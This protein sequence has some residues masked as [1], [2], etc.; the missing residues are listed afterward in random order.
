M[1]SDPKEKGGD[2]DYQKGSGVDEALWLGAF[3]CV[4]LV[5]PFIELIKGW[6]TLELESSRVPCWSQT[7]IGGPPIATIG[8]LP[9]PPKQGVLPS[10]GPSGYSRTFQKLLPIIEPSNTFKNTSRD[11]RNTMGPLRTLP[12][13]LETLLAPTRW[14]SQIASPISDASRCIS[15]S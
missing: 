4:L 12:R 11:H 15:L 13:T 14:P 8:Y 1:T 5:C 2:K 3:W 9:P 7:P 10:I 6:P